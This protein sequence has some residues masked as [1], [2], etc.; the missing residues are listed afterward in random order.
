MDS[1]DD[2]VPKQRILIGREL[3]YRIV[4]LIHL[5]YAAAAAIVLA[6]VSTDHL[7]GAPIDYGGVLGTAAALL[8]WNA[9]LHLFVHE[10]RFQNWYKAG[11]GLATVQVVVDGLLLTVLIH[12][13]GGLD[14]PL[15]FFYVFHGIIAAILLSRRAAWLQATLAVVLL[16]GLAVLEQTGALPHNHIDVLMHVE[17]LV[18]CAAVL[19]GVAA[20]LYLAVYMTGTLSREMLAREQ[21]CLLD[22][23]R[24][25]A[26]DR[27]KSD[28]VR[29]I[30]H[31]LKDPLSAIISTLRVVLDGYAGEVPERALS[32][33]ARA[34]HRAD[35]LARLVRELLDLSRIRTQAS[36]DRSRWS[37]AALVRDVV[38]QLRPQAESKRQRIELALPQDP[39]DVWANRT[40]IEQVFVN[41]VGNAIKYTPADGRIYVSVHDRGS[42][43]DAQVGDTGIGVPPDAQAR[44]FDEFYRAPNARHLTRDGSGLGL[45]FVRQIVAAYDGRVTVQSPWLPPDASQPCG[46]LFT[47]DLGWHVLR[48]DE[49]GPDEGPAAASPPPAA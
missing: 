40:A 24:L 7:L 4:W 26:Q 41:L 11:Y 2:V 1:Y 37:F 28:Y 22:N 5:R 8:G 12:Q 6:L 36:E 15:V 44:I 49:A 23:A 32:L 33:V 10:V 17:G 25:V 39:L 21:R 20:T 31:D 29:L 47:V 42:R 46:A 30:A 34:E 45:S 3:K 35:G 18:P 9:A 48:P 16:T 14:N 19:L 43:F 13:T 27:L 38:D